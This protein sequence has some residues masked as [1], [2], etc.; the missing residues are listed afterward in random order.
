MVPLNGFRNDFLTLTSHNQEVNMIGCY[1][2]IQ[3]R[4]TE[5]FSLK[6]IPLAGFKGLHQTTD[7]PVGANL[8]FALIILVIV[9][10]P[11]IAP[12]NPEEPKNPGPR[13]KIRANTRGKTRANTRFAPTGM[14]CC[15]INKGT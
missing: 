12:D 13:T 14:D 3:D 9:L 6:L 2:V 15:Y 1:L 5:L 4:Q 7:H 11:V 8:V 10:I